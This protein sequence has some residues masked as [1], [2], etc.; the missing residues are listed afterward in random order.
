M[1]KGGCQLKGDPNTTQR[2][3]CVWERRS[4][5]A[6]ELSRYTVRDS[7]RYAVRDDEG[8]CNLY[9]QFCLRGCQ[10]TV[11]YN[12]SVTSLRTGDTSPYT[13][14][15]FRLRAGRE[16]TS[17]SGSFVAC[18]LPSRGAKGARPVSFSSIY[19]RQFPQHGRHIWRPYGV[20]RTSCKDRDSSF[21]CWKNGRCRRTTY[22]KMQLLKS[23]HKPGG[24]IML[25]P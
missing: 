1:C 12:P 17:Q 13:G 15:A 16:D 20:Q 18:Q 24:R 10:R 6:R 4:D 2:S 7:G 25:L 5:E 11:D 8:D 23:L 22:R 3:G 21:C 14:E 19:D 9:I